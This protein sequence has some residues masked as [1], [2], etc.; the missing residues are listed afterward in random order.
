M[1]PAKV[2]A[3]AEEAMRLLTEEGG[4]RANPALLRKI[5]GLISE[6]LHHSNH[7]LRISEKTTQLRT[8]SEIYF[9]PRKHL[10]Y[11]SPGQS[12]LSKV[13]SIAYQAAYLIAD[14]ADSLK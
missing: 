6:M 5:E 2:K 8:Y 7:D 4:G 14:I 3:A 11:D 1:N 13:K 12:G 10:K 9:S